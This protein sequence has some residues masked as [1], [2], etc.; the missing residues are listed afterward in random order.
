MDIVIWDI[1]KPLL[2]M[3]WKTPALWGRGDCDAR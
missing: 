2:A 1:E 3:H